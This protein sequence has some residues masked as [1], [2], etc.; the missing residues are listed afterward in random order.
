M[1]RVVVLTGATGGV[2]RATAR[3]LAREGAAIALIARDPD[4]LEATAAEVRALGG[5]PLAIAVDVADADAVEAAATR[6]EDELGP[7]DV[8]IND[9]MTSVLAFVRDVSAE[10]FRQVTATTYLGVVNGTLSALRRMLPRNR[11]VIVQV[12]SA[13]AYRGIP[14]QAP[15]CAAKH[16][17]KGFTESLRA[18]LLHDRSR[19]RVTMV[20]LPGLNTTQFDWVRTRLP[21]APRPVAPVYQPEVAARAV[22]WASRHPRR[23]ELWVGGSTVLAIAG[24]K[25]LPGIGDRYLARTAVEAQQTDRRVGP[26]RRRT[27]DVDAPVPGDRGAHGPFDDE[28]SRRSAQLWLTCHRRALWSGAAALAAGLAAGAAGRRR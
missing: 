17:V 22:V 20:H 27:D 8:W 11:G 9:A 13:L 18:E 15:Y 26:E 16:A 6:V 10:E 21:R 1:S 14:L 3:A 23:R 19:V 25:L 7:I 24:A 28:G 4:Q 12:G 5:T 2:G